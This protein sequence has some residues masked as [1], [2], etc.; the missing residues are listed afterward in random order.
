[1]H[2]TFSV[3]DAEKFGSA[4]LAAIVSNLRFWLRKN[5]ANETNIHDGRVWTYNSLDAWAK[6]F[7]WLSVSQVKRLLA[8]LEKGGFLIKGNYSK[9]ALNKTT[10]YSLDEPD[11]IVNRPTAPETSRLDDS[12]SSMGRNR[13]MEG[14]ESSHVTDNKQTDS[15]SV[16][17]NARDSEFY[18]RVMTELLADGLP[19]REKRYAGL[20]VKEY[21][22][23]FPASSSVADCWKYVVTAVNHSA[24]LKG[25]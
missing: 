23:R 11:F 6:L 9:N 16:K 4:D 1:M 5:L 20:K 7:P 3:A 17:N 24:G 14:T 25:N 13:P 15:K 12:V 21:T 10:W 22:E 8:K 18:N 2:Y 19:A